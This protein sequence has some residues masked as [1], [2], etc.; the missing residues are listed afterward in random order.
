LKKPQKGHQ[1][2]LIQTDES[3]KRPKEVG[4]RHMREVNPTT[5]ISEF[6]IGDVIGPD[7]FKAGDRVDV[8][9]TSKGKGFAG[10]MKRHNFKGGPKTHGQSDRRRAPGSIGAGTTPGRVVKGMRMAG[11]MGHARVTTQN[12]TVVRV[13]TEKNL[14]LIKGAVPGANGGLVII[15]KAVK[16]GK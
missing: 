5:A 3:G 8:T 7:I 2:D 11:H 16:T 10:V 9:G 12:L 15:R 4:L 6:N 14:V 1:K 13:E